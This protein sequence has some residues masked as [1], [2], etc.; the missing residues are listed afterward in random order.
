MYSITAKLRYDDWHINFECQIS[1][2]NVNATLDLT[3]EDLRS[4]E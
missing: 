3:L 1:K 2:G 4:Q